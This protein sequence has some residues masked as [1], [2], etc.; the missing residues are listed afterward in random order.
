MAVAPGQRGDLRAQHLRQRI[1]IGRVGD[2]QHLRHAGDLRGFGGHG[3][4]VGS[5]HDDIDGFRRQ[6]DGGADGLGGGGVELAVQ[7][8]GDDQNLAHHSSPFCLSA[9]TSSAASLTITPL[10]RFAGG[11]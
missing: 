5:Q 8:F 7:V 6:R 11:A 9:A 3:G 1:G 10:L 4:R 2:G